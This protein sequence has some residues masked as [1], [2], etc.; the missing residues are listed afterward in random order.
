MGI[1]TPIIANRHIALRHAVM[2]RHYSSVLTREMLSTR[3]LVCPTQLLHAPTAASIHGLIQGIPPAIHVHVATRR[4]LIAVNMTGS[5]PSARR[6]A[7]KRQ[8]AASS[9]THRYWYPSRSSSSVALTAFHSARL[10]TSY[11][12][13]CSL[14]SPTKYIEDPG[15]PCC[16]TMSPAPHNKGRH[17][18]APQHLHAPGVTWWH[19]STCMPRA[20]GL[21]PT[22]LLLCTAGLE[23]R[24]TYQAHPSTQEHVVLAHEYMTSTRPAGWASTPSNNYNALATVASISM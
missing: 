3:Q 21:P 5:P 8:P 19:H 24:S 16:S 20:S 1:S 15:S 11:T 7:D 12:R 18:V 9:I 23:A 22:T 6:D 13:T 4:E 2:T 10:V 14:P 17:L